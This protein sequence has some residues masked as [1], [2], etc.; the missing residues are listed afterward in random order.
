M[1]R[2]RPLVAALALLAPALLLLAPPALAAGL[3]PE[4]A[5]IE[6]RACQERGKGSFDKPKRVCT[7]MVEGLSESLSAAEYEALSILLAGGPSTPEAEAAHATAKL[8]VEQC[9]AG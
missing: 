5:K 8:I 4:Q 6:Q 7:C 2:T 1:T 3:T 9:L